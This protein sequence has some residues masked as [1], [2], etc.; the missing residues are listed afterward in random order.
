MCIFF[1]SNKWGY[2]MV[3]WRYQIS[4]W[5]LST[6]N[7]WGIFQHLNLPLGIAANECVYSTQCRQWQSRLM[8]DLP[9]LT[10]LSC[11][12]RFHNLSRALMSW[13]PISPAKKSHFWSSI[14]FISKVDRKLKLSKESG[15]W[16]LIP[17]GSPLTREFE[18]S[19]EQL[20]PTVTTFRS[21]RF[22]ALRFLL[23]GG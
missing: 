8:T 15:M 12:L 4:L 5:V 18:T 23:F 2:Y 19:R 16:L 17:T 3:M 14:G 11:V 7:E 1:V 10:T 13:Q 20:F 22:R 9:S 21:S 6:A